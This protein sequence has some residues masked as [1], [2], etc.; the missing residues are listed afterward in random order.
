M[1]DLSVIPSEGSSLQIKLSL[2]SQA[3]SEVVDDFERMQI[4]DFARA[5]QE[6]A[7]VLKHKAIQVQAA[8]LV[9]DA[10]RAIAKANPPN[11]GGKGVREKSSCVTPNN[12]TRFS[13]STIRQIRLAHSALGDDQYNEIKQTA[14]KESEPLTRATLIKNANALIN[15]T[16]RQSMVENPPPLPTGEYRTIVIDPPWPIEKIKRDVRPEQQ[17][18]DYPTMTLDEIAG[19]RLPVAADAFV[20]LWTTQKHLPNAFDLLKKWSLKYRFTMGWLKPGGFQPFDL[21]KFNLEFVVVG[22]LGNPIFIDFKAFKVGF[23]APQ[24]G[25]SVKPDSF[26]EVVRRVT[27]PPRI[28]MFSRRPITGF[29]AWGNE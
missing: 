25:H 5:V 29:D 20:F 26:Y 8:N 28:D 9:Q 15:R 19:L 13:P 12:T 17:G 14:I 4:R 10:E 2:V 18:Y 11:P 22:A 1:Q 24:Q 23:S 7:M 21:P 16:R 3:L 6:A 27:S